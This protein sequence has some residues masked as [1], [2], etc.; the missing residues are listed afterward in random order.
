MPQTI[1]VLFFL[2][3]FNSYAEML[4]KVAAFLFLGIFLLNSFGYYFIFCL[5][6]DVMHE[7][8]RAVIRS[9]YFKDHY[10]TLELEKLSANP[11]FRW[12]DKD[13]F[14]YKG[15]LYDLISIERTKT[16]VVFH[17]INDT[18]E[19]QLIANNIQLRDLLTGTNSPERAKTHQALQDLVI[20]HALVDEHPSFDPGIFT[21]IHFYNPVESLHSV[22]LS[23]VSPPPR[24]S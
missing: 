11:D 3:R 24:Q 21:C 20:K 7:E 2:D 4:K 16:G 6:Q 22:A 12:M 1:L 17:C 19:E 14:M 23:P 9:G 8:M 5:N 10:E 13:E 15:K 18:K